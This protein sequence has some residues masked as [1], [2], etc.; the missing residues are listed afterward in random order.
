MLKICRI[1]HYK[2]SGMPIWSCNQRSGTANNS[3]TTIQ[4]D[5]QIIIGIQGND[6]LNYISQLLTTA[7]AGGTFGTGRAS[8]TL[9]AGW[10]L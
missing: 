10:A 9:W 4:G 1:Y 6:L 2:Y 5:K 3:I 7:T 8:W